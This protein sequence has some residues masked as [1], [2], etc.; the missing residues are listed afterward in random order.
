MP[1]HDQVFDMVTVLYQ[2]RQIYFGHCDKAQA[3]FTRMGFECA[4]RQTT[5]DFLTSLTNPVE[6]LIRDGYRDKTPRTPEDF[7]VAWENSPEYA[8]LLQD[9][10]TYEKKNPLGGESVA[11]FVDYRR[12]QQAEHQ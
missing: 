3:F 11:R 2:G 8:Q 5:A 9:I 10:G 1:K 7:V 6:R 12:R 4:P